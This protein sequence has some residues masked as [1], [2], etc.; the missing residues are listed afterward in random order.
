MVT[1]G[2][3]TSDDATVTVAT[4]VTT[5]TVVTIAP[6]V[7]TVTVAGKDA[8]EAAVTVVTMVTMAAVAAHDLLSQPTSDGLEPIFF[9]QAFEAVERGCHDHRWSALP[10]RQARSQRLGLHPP[11]SW[12]HVLAHV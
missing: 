8:N 10:Q 6:S 7:V 1:T 9:T 2:T 11:D 3:V 5:V 12:R 4:L